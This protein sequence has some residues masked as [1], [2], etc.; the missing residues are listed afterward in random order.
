MAQTRPGSDRQRDL[1]AVLDTSPAHRAAIADLVD[2]LGFATCTFAT[3]ADLLACPWIA[4]IRAILSEMRLP[5]MTALGLLH[6]LR[7]RGLPVPVIVMVGSPD[8]PTE[9]RALQYGA[10]GYLPKPLE[11]ERLLA[12]LTSCMS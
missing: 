8:A 4:E 12:L 1:V 10:L 11:P 7:G 9:A 6:T 3:P 5:G 2:A